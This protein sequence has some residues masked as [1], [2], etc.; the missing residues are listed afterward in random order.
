VLAELGVTASVQ[1]LFDRWWG[2]PGGLYEQRL[3]DRHRGMN[4]FAAMHAAGVTLALG[5]DSPVTPVAPWQAVR[6]AGHHHDPAQRL[7]A[8]A[9]LDA[10][11]RGGWAAARL[12][13]G[14]LEPG[15][16]AD[17]AVWDVT[18]LER[19][20]DPE[21]DVPRCLLTL[22]GGRIAHDPDDLAQRDRGGS[23]A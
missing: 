9:A 3:G 15:A 7:P 10:H 12:E 1:P 4:P 2:G 17:L 11:A 6:A 14:T 23:R 5:S 19:A 8:Q 18:T 16:P 22:V 20:L 21:A 13:G